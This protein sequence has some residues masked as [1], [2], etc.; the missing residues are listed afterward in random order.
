MRK[1]P[2]F[3]EAMRCE[4]GSA[5]LVGTDSG[6]ISEVVRPIEVVYRVAQKSGGGGVVLRMVCCALFT[7]T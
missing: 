5:E 2:G 3:V 7:F 1:T 6:G 4:G